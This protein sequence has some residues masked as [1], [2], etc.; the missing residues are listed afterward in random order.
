MPLSKRI[1][2]SL[3]ALVLV[4]AWTG[5]FLRAAP[6]GTMDYVGSAHWTRAQDIEIRGTLAYVA[7]ING[8]GI[9]DVSDVKRPVKISQLFLG[10]GYAVAV[11]QDLAFVAAGTKGLN[12]V[13]I[14]DPKS[15][16]LKSVLPTTGEAREVIVDGR[17]VFVAAGDQGLLVVDAENP[18]S[19]KLIG[20][21]DSPGEGLSLAKRDGFVYLA[22][23]SAGL[24][25]ID[26]VQPSG[27]KLLGTLDTDGTAESVAVIDRYAYVADGASGLS[28]VDIGIPSVPKKV[29]VLEASGYAHSVSADGRTL[30]LGSLYDGGYQVFDISAPDA[31]I[32]ASTNKYTMYNEG[33][34]VV[35]SGTFATVVDYFSGLFFV[36]IAEP[37]KPVPAGTFFTP[38][39][40]VAT[41]AQDRYSYSVGE[42]SGLQALD[43]SDPAHPVSTAGTAIFRG[44]QSLTVA[45]GYAYVTDRWSVRIFDIADPAKPRLATVWNMPSGVP[46]AI[47]VRGPWAYLTADNAGFFVLSLENPRAPKIA[48]SLSLGGFTYG[49]AVSGDYAYLANSDSGLHVV[50]IADPAAPVEAGGLKLEGEPSG[51]A[52]RGTLAY[53]ASGPAGLIVVDVGRPSVP[54]TLGKLAAGDFA[55]AIAL[56]GDFAYM[57]DG[58]AG[59]KKIDISDPA[60]P[61]LVASFDTPGQAQ[62]VTTSGPLVL[63]SDTHS[64][65]IVK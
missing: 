56:A 6:P 38:S 17:Y 43:L 55:S 4:S 3:L 51:V 42:L 31:P 41:A 24:A 34:R 28:V 45:G 37:K 49:L 27:P 50:N 18:S 62:S 30:C 5:S 22:D 48:G 53:I 7:F 15:P 32:L 26:V 19:P 54:K 13:D 39:S 47:V 65:I 52:V 8:L 9:L 35:V 64:V 11:R 20:Q 25:V 46:R 21:W 12:I 61:K 29:R 60:G 16:V 14:S 44:V 2:R 23:G 36:N 1:Q 10:G 40:I 57:A 59:V 58:N 33:W 63:V